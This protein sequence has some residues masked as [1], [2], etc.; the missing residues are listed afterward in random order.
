[1]SRS[2]DRLALLLLFMLYGSCRTPEISDGLPRL[3]ERNGAVRLIVDDQPF[4]MIAGE[5]HNSSA[6]CL[7]SMDSLFARLAALNLNTV[8]APVSWEL[9]EPREGEFDFTLVDGLIARARANNLKLV[10]LWFGS[11]KNTESS[12]VPAWVK[13]DARRFFRARTRSGEQREILSAF[14]REAQKAD[15]RAFAALLRHLREV[16]SFDKTV[17]MVQVE[18]E[19]GLLGDARDFCPAADTAFH[20]PVPPQLLD[21]L[22]RWESRLHPELLAAWRRDAYGTWQQVFGEAAEEVFSAWHI[23]SYVEA[24]ARAGKAEYPLPMYVNAWLRAEGQKPGE[25]P[26]GGP[27]DKVI[28]VWRSAAPS[29]DLFA[30]DIYL[31]NFK[32]ICADYARNGNPLLIPET[33]RNGESTARAL[34]AFAQHNALCCAPFGI[35][36]ILDPLAFQKGCRFL[37]SLAPILTTHCGGRDMAGVLQESGETDTLSLGEYLFFIRYRAKAG[38]GYGLIV[39]TGVDTFLVGGSGFEL[40]FLSKC[41]TEAA[42]RI[43]QVDELAYRDG[44]WR[45]GRRLNGDETAAHQRVIVPELLNP[46][47]A[48]GLQESTTHPPLPKPP[49]E[50]ALQ[51]V[52]VYRL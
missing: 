26:S 36:D 45:L 37:K 17:L 3:E 35:E 22:R 21:S 1:M 12:Y 15:A 34:Y 48:A 7:D 9:I 32:Q 30:P 6:S 43:L 13:R 33:H 29:I 27:I 40:R 4:L 44:D 2:A 18:N 46:D 42:P 19:T 5:L 51:R 10:L 25:Y 49:E 14:C 23:A 28:A 47:L 39:R 16:D 41:E 50:Y 8:L 11:W 52:I 31:P 38:R 24:V 20:S